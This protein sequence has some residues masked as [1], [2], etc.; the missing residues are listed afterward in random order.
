MS[1]KKA[2]GKAEN[3]TDS[4]P[5]YLGVKLYDGEQASEGAIII[6][7]RGN[8]YEAGKNV[9]VSKDYTI[10][11]AKQGVVRFSKTRK[12]RFNGDVIVKSI[13]SVE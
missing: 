2:A 11:A 5:Q 10:H 3:L 12:N 1:S 8:K 6:R 4:G 7:Q 13:V 9:F